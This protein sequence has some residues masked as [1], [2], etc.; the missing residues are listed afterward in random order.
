MSRQLRYKYR[1]HVQKTKV[2]LTMSR[3]SP[4]Q[5]SVRNSMVVSPSFGGS[6]GLHPANGQTVSCKM[7]QMAFRYFSVRQERAHTYFYSYGQ[8]CRYGMFILDPTTN[9]EATEK[10]VFNFFCSTKLKIISFWSTGK[11]FC[12]TDKELV[13]FTQ[14]IFTKLQEILIGDIVSGNW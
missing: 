8:C 11:F 9:T 3:M 6:S 5:S 7:L 14:E 13:F 12:Q 2:F 4:R 10:F 1:Y